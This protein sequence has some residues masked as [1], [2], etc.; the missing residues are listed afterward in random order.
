MSAKP[1]RVAFLDADGNVIETLPLTDRNTVNPFSSGATGYMASGKTILRAHDGDDTKF[2]VSCSVVA[3]GSKN[4]QLAEVAAQRR[5]VREA[6]QE[7]IKELQGQ[8]KH[9]A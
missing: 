6:L 5:S 1:V 2:Q 3:I 8:M 7:K 9:T 4:E